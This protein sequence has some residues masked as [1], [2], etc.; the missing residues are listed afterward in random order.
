MLQLSLVTG[1]FIF[2]W[3]NKPFVNTILGSINLTFSV[4]AG[5]VGY[6]SLKPAPIFLLSKNNENEALLSY[7]HFHNSFRD[8]G[9]AENEVDKMKE[10]VIAEDSRNISFISIHSLRTLLLVILAKLTFVALFNATQNSIKIIL[11][12]PILSGK[13]KLFVKL[14]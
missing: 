8:A 14:L 6:F 1:L 2:S 12:R 4:L 9:Q 13:S 10:Y 5:I 11:L 7:K 3:V